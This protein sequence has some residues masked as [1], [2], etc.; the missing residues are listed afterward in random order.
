[1]EGQG[2]TA[3]AEI[4]FKRSK[5]RPVFG[6]PLWQLVAIAASAEAAILMLSRML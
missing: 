2:G 3:V 1:M 5:R 6:L 4:Q